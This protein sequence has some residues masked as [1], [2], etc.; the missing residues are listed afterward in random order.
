MKR[1]PLL[2]ATLLLVSAC[3]PKEPRNRTT[4]NVMTFN[5]RYDN[6]DDSL[7]VWARRLPRVT[8]FLDSVAPDL[9]GAQEVL[10]NQ[11]ED[12]SAAL[13]GYDR[14]GV[15]RED[16][17]RE[18]EYQPLFWRRDRFRAVDKGYFWL[19]ETPEKPSLG[20][21][22]ACKRT[23]VWAILRDSI[24]GREILV[25]NTHLDHMG[26]VARSESV[27]LLIERAFTL[28]DGRE[29]ILTGDFNATPSSPVIT[30]L[31]RAFRDSRQE[32]G[33]IS[34]ADWSFHDFGK[35]SE[36]ERERIDYI[37]VSP[38]DLDIV[39][40]ETPAEDD[41]DPGHLYLSDHAPVLTELEIRY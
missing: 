16:G 7:N 34:G 25:M 19:S 4:L 23:A 5:V 35:I 20:W 15:G 26:K 40:N 10:H 1:L 11:L 13:P 12:L 37:F 33:W 36:P 2:L 27:K 29:I 39:R 8:A 38:G 31:G 17:L 30:A 21:D 6:P 9:L 32:A 28:A 18:G 24:S 22:A 3:G 14:Y 41:S